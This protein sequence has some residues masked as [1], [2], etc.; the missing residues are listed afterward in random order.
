M[1]LCG[2]L[3]SG[4]GTTENPDPVDRDYS[5]PLETDARVVAPLPENV[6]PGRPVT[7]AATTKSETKPAA[8]ETTAVIL[9]SETTVPVILPEETTAADTLIIETTAAETTAETKPIEIPLDGAVKVDIGKKLTEGSTVSGQLVSEQS[10]KLLLLVDYRCRRESDGSV[11]LEVDVGLQCYD[12]NCGGRQD[13]CWLMINGEKHPYTTPGLSLNS[14]TKNYIPFTKYTGKI[15]AGQDF[16]RIDA[17]WS[18]N[19]VY[20]GKKIKEL[21]T[22]AVLVWG[23]FAE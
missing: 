7:S 9:P 15:D 20:G 16:C 11:S 22:S 3:L 4:C 6:E 19:G 23:D 14:H 13:D 18:F 8:P 2:L 1:L 12:V 10:E 5:M 17:Q 21:S